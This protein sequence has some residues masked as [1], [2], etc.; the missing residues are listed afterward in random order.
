[1]GSYYVEHRL[2][3]LLVVSIK[4]EFWSNS[5]RKEW[6]CIYRKGDAFSLNIKRSILV[7]VFMF[8]VLQRG[9]IGMEL[10]IHCEF[11]GLLV[12]SSI[13]SCRD[14]ISL[15]AFFSSIVVFNPHCFFFV[16]LFKDKFWIW[17]QQSIH[18]VEIAL[19]LHYHLLLYTLLQ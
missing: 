6:V 11:N 9:S 3:F 8:P 7:L 18:C 1:M 19:R 17:K 12:S 4:N 15:V 5:C 2:L 10:S 14:S 13:Y 16:F